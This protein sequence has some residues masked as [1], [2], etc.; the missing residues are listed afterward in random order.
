MNAE[1]AAIVRTLTE[2]IRSSARRAVR[3]GVTERGACS[4]F[5]YT[6]IADWRTKTN[7]RAVWLD[8]ISRY[9]VKRKKKN[10]S[11]DGQRDQMAFWDHLD[12]LFPIQRQAKVNPETGETVEHER[13]ELVELG[14]FGIPEIEQHDAQLDGNISNAQAE[15]ALWERAKSF[16]VPLLK[17]QKD[18]K[19]R[20]AVEHMRSRGTLPDLL[21]T[22]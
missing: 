20:D 8:F 19:W 10:K 6:D 14:D 17:R 16:V 15:R 7:T 13:T 22:Q 2:A 4:R 3:K 5:I 9:S 18:W 1:V 12:Q 21:V 11:K